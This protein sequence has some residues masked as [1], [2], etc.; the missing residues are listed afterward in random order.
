MDF[1]PFLTIRQP[2][3]ESRMRLR[4][5]S[6]CIWYPRFS[7]FQRLIRSSMTRMK[8]SP[9]FKPRS[10]GMITLVPSQMAPDFTLQALDGKDKAQ[11]DEW[12]GQVDQYVLGLKEE[13][14]F[15]GISAEQSAITPQQGEQPVRC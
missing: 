11:V 12:A 8:C 5:M 7:T 10:I 2:S 9:V 6:H 15:R 1:S 14:I 3:M 4:L 13:T